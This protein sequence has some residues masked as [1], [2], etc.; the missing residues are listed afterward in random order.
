[1]SHGDRAEI[2]SHHMHSKACSLPDKGQTFLLKSGMLTDSCSFFVL[3]PGGTQG[4]KHF[5]G[6]T[7]FKRNQTNYCCKNLSE[8]TPSV[9]N[10]RLSDARP[11]LH[12]NKENFKNYADFIH[13]NLPWENWF[14]IQN[15]TSQLFLKSKIWKVFLKLPA[16]TS[17][18][19][20]YPWH[21]WCCCFTG[22]EIESCKIK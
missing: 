15:G 14:E 7:D 5:P 8:K 3:F 16:F 4:N 11:H 12:C 18:E 2:T 9:R 10:D 1:M 21:Y 6:R 22:E 20:Y 17:V 13:F 19:Q